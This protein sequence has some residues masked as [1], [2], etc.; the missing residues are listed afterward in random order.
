MTSKLKTLASW[1]V[2]GVGRF[3]F[4]DSAAI[5]LSPA[6]GQGPA[7]CVPVCD[8]GP[9]ICPKG[10]QCVVWVSLNGGPCIGPSDNCNDV[11]LGP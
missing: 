7:Q 6:M 9:C 8:A 10:E 1:P 4:P 3:A 2:I 5:F 11:C